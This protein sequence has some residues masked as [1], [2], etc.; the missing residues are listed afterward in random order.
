MHLVGVRHSCPSETVV[1]NSSLVRPA[2]ICKSSLIVRSSP[3]CLRSRWV[4]PVPWSPPAHTAVFAVVCAN[5]IGRRCQYRQCLLCRRVN[6]LYYT[7]STRWHCQLFICCCVIKEIPDQTMQTPRLKSCYF[8][9]PDQP[10]LH[11]KQFMGFIL[12]PKFL[13][14]IFQLHNCRPRSFQGQPRSLILEPIESAYSISY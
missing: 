3:V 9:K 2:V 4:S 13:M 11:P 1:S 8:R 5:E 12:G 10:Y 14:L 7:L 6:S